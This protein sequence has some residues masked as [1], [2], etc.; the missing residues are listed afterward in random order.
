MTVDDIA[1]C[2]VAALLADTAHDTLM[3]AKG[4]HRAAPGNDWVVLAPVPVVADTTHRPYQ[5][6]EY[7][8]EGCVVCDANGDTGGWPCDAVAARYDGHVF[9]DPTV[10]SHEPDTTG[11]EG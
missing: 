11:G 4:G 10:T 1:E 5:S 2:V 6:D 3:A 7:D 8:Y 9:Y